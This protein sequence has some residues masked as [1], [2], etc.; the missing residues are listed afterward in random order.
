MNGKCSAIRENRNRALVNE[1]GIEGTVLFLRQFED[2]IGDYTAAR[3]TLFENMTIDDLAAQIRQGH[4][5]RHADV[6]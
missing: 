5:E 4:E 3:E 2:G 6:V 1:L